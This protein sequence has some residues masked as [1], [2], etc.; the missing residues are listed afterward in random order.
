MKENSDDKPIVAFSYAV[1][2]PVKDR[3]VMF[4]Y[5]YRG[6]EKKEIETIML[7]LE[8][9]DFLPQLYE[10]QTGV[11]LGTLYLMDQFGN[12]LDKNHPSVNDYYDY[13]EKSVSR[14]RKFCISG[15]RFK[16]CYYDLPFPAGIENKLFQREL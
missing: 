11:K 3:R 7:I 14:I 15:L 9:Q 1:D 10:G 13:I 6:K 2:I 8:M 5:P 16:A 4:F 12:V